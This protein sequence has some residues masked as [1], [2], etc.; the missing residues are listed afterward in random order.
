MAN[1]AVKKPAAKP[2]VKTPRPKVIIKEVHNP[3]LGKKSRQSARVARPPNKY[4][5]NEGGKKVKINPAVGTAPGTQDVIIYKDSYMNEHGAMAYTPLDSV[6]MPALLAAIASTG[7]LT[8]SCER[9]NI[10]RL[11]VYAFKAENK[12]FARRLME[13]QQLG[14]EAWKDEAA[15]R[16]FQGFDRPIFQQGLQ[17]GAERQFSDTLALALLK[18]ADPEHFQDRTRMEHALGGAASQGLFLGKSE[19]EVN[20]ALTRKLNSVSAVQRTVNQRSNVID[21]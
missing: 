19:E 2:A 13:A 18:A 9:L 16:A 5:I 4:V 20:E 17:V 10:S 7:N 6:T 21:V 8:L 11:A 12:D 1:P 3:L 14:V 15:R